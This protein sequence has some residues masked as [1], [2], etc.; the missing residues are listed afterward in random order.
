MIVYQGFV[1][2]DITKCIK[3]YTSISILEGDHFEVQDPDGGIGQNILG[4]VRYRSDIV[5]ISQLCLLANRPFYVT[6]YL[7]D[8]KYCTLSWYTVIMMY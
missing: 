1:F 6:R 3:Q 8:H 5:V 4:I 2:C 7:P